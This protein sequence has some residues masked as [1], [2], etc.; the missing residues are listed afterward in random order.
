[1]DY[2]QLSLFGKTSQEPLV[3]TKEKI[4]GSSSK[5]SSRSSSR[6]PMCLEY[7]KV[8]GHTPI[9]G[10][11]QNGALLTELSTLNTGESPSD[12]VESTLSSILEAD[13]PER[14][15]LS[16]R[17]CEG[18]L[19]RA[20]RRGKELPQTLREALEYVISQSHTQ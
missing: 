10:W 1:M 4:S 20:E 18:I 13:V 15:Y 7:R 19:R 11:V 17:A 3:Q 2:I 9:A 14:Y 16:A 8:D 5:R 6:K 12:A